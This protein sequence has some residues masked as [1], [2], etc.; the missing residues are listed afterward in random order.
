MELGGII[1]LSERVDILTQA[2]DR[3]AEAIDN[4]PLG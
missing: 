4:L 3:A 2:V 1:D